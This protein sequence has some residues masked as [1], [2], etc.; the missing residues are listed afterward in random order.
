[1]PKMIKLLPLTLFLLAGCGVCYDDSGEVC[2]SN[3]TD[4]IVSEDK[5]TAHLTCAMKND[6]NKLP[7]YS[8]LDKNYYKIEKTSHWY[9]NTKL[10]IYCDF[11][12][13]FIT[14]GDDLSEVIKK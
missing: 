5:T 7:G 10:H 4:Q 1:M 12:K 14:N 6:S 11:G 13:E 8:I 3:K 2:E 9:T